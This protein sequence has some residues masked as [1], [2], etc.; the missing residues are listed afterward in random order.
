[1]ADELSPWVPCLNCNVP[2]YVDNSLFDSFF[3]QDSYECYKCHCS[4]D[5]E[6]LIKRA[7]DM[8][9]M[10]NG[11]FNLLGLPSKLIPFTLKQNQVT[12][13]NFIDHGLPKDAQIVWINYTSQG[14][15]LVPIQMHGNTPFTAFPKN[16]VAIYPAAFGKQKESESKAIAFIMWSEHEEAHISFIIDAIDHYNHGRYPESITPLNIA[17]ETLL[18]NVLFNHFSETWSEK[19]AERMMGALDYGF[20]L[21]KLLPDLIEANAWIALPKEIRKNL[22]NLLEYRNQIVHSG[23][24]KKELEKSELVNIMTSVLLAYHFCR[25]VLE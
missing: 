11:V 1:M 22:T 6:P 7:I 23:E 2:L 16:E 19:V 9:F 3:S 13:L 5:V 14:G 25:K 21:N 24:L 8:N 4:I 18:K 20:I 10:N 15:D 17:I 12:I